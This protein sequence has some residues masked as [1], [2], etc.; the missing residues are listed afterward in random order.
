MN[1]I[2]CFKALTLALVL[3]TFAF[4]PTLRADTPATQPTTQ[5][6]TGIVNKTCPVG[7][8]DVDPAVTT[9]YDGKTIGFCCEGCVKKFKKNPEKYMK[10]LK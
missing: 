10:D 8:D 6:S 9:V 3:S 7:G 5:T 2:I 1:R 4:I